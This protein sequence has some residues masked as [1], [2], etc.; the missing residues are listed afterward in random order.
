MAWFSSNHRGHESLQN[1]IKRLPPFVKRALDNGTSL[2]GRNIDT[3]G[4]EEELFSVNFVGVMT[5]VYLISKHI[6]SW[7]AG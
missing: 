7:A 4:S 2:C 5:S 6:A 3:A 1:Y